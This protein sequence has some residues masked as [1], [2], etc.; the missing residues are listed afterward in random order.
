LYNYYADNYSDFNRRQT[1]FEYALEKFLQL[2]EKIENEKFLKLS[3]E[4]PSS[5]TI[6]VRRIHREAKNYAY[7][8][9][10][11]EFEFETQLHELVEKLWDKAD[12]NG[13]LAYTTFIN[14]R[15]S[16]AKNELELR[17]SE[18][19]TGLSSQIEI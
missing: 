5:D 8:R 6:E 13:S 10:S 15:N 14:E 7:D 9:V 12:V 4:L 18:V 17:I 11:S 16:R 1:T 2:K 19:E 3:A